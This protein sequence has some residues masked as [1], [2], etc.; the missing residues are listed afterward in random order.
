MHG[1]TIQIHLPCYL[2]LP[3]H[4]AVN[5]QKIFWTH[6]RQ[7]PTLVIKLMLRLGLATVVTGQSMFLSKSLDSYT[8][9]CQGWGPENCKNTM[10]VTSFWW[11]KC[12]GKGK[13]VPLQV[14]SG[15]EGSIKLRF[16]DF[17]TKAQDGGNVVSL[18]H[19]PPLPQETHLVLISVR[20]CV[21]RRAIVR[22]EGL[23]HWKIPMTPLGIETVTW[24]FVV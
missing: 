2:D 18:M 10:Y 13:A 22:P 8:R 1:A 14:W 5:K 20:G 17:M 3:P 19:R 23:C 7:Y 12:K 16:P 24:R 21:D 6:L 4:I 15:P 9:K 11:V